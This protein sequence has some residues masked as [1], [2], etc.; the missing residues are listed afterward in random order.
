MT[1]ARSGLF[2]GRTAQ[3][4]TVE[5][6]PDNRTDVATDAPDTGD[7]RDAKS[8]RVLRRVRE[9]ADRDG[10]GLRDTT[11]RDT[12]ERHTGDTLVETDR[13]TDRV[14]ERTSVAEHADTLDPDAVPVEPIRPA[15]TSL[16][17]TLGIVAGVA[18]T[19]AALTGLLAA[20]GI[21][22]GVLG[23][24]LSL[25]GISAGSRRHVAGRGPGMLG[26]LFSLAAI[27]LGV[28][29]V[30]HSVAWL[31]SDVDQVARLRDWMDAQMTWLRS[32]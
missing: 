5:T 4:R 13:R 31:D 3:D 17:A 6:D 23:L 25:G 10:D 2:G 24:L 26:L 21:A 22:L 29:A 1:V 7:G 32:Q 18:A 28:L 14:A 11:T 15:R 30:T 20:V 19:A 12:T 27:A 16:L 8:T 9:D